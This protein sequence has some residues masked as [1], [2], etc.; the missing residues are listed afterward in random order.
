MSGA[1]RIFETYSKVLLRPYVLKQTKNSSGLRVKRKAKV[2]N[3]F[4][5]NIL[6]IL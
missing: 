3:E 2:L 5:G 4:T 1:A 6:I